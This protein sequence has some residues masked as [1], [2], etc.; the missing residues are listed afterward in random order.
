MPRSLGRGSLLEE[1]VFDFV[2]FDELTAP[3]LFRTH[4][5]AF[6]CGRRQTCLL[7]G[8]AAC[9]TDELRPAVVSAFLPRFVYG[10][11][12]FDVDADVD[13]LGFRIRFRHTRVL[14]TE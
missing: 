7:D 11:K 9:L 5:K 8:V 10:F 6:E 4:S 3:C 14:R 2:A 13:V 12:E 1:L